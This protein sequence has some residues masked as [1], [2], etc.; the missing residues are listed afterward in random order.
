MAQCF[1][2]HTAFCW[3]PMFGSQHPCIGS[4]PP[5]I[6]VLKIYSP[7]QTP[8]G[9]THTH[10]IKIKT[11]IAFKSENI[12]RYLYTCYCN[13][14]FI[15]GQ[16]YEEM[17]LSSGLNGS[18]LAT[19]SSSPKGTLKKR[20][21]KEC[22]SQNVVRRNVKCVLDKTQPL[23]MWTHSSSVYLHQKIP[24]KTAGGMEQMLLR[25]CFWLLC[26]G[27]LMAAEGGKV[28]SLCGRGPW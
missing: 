17:W 5:V 10:K 20:S 24:V 18:S 27:Q 12:Q 11:I 6:P 25:S 26:Y 23:H 13:C 16:S 19:L 1:R 15:A 9:T 8:V 28:T 3:G 22:K 14:R 7:L 4:Q 2:V 21:Q